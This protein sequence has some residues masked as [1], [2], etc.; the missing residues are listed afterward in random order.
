MCPRQVLGAEP[1]TQVVKL[2]APER[3]NGCGLCELLCPDYVL[4]LQPAPAA[5]REAAQ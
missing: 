4:S 3:C 5:A 1:V 2:V